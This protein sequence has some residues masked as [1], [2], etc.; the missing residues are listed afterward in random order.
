MPMNYPTVP[1]EI[2]STPTDIITILSS[3]AAAFLGAAAA[4]W[5]N[6]QERKK[7]E[8]RQRRELINNAIYTVSITVNTLINIKSQQL[9]LYKSEFQEILKC[10]SELNLHRPEVVEKTRRATAEILSKISQTD[11]NLNDVFKVWQ[12]TEFLTITAPE[13]LAFTVEETPDLV[14]LLM[15][16]RSEVKQVSKRTAYR[17]SVHTR[18][19][20]T[21]RGEMASGVPGPNTLIFWG[22]M[23]SLRLL[24][25]DHVD[26]ALGIVP[27]IIDQIGAYRT[28]AFKKT[29]LRKI[30]R[31]KEKWLVF[32]L[33]GKWKTFMPDRN[34]YQHIIRGV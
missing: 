29:L 30:L 19:E 8:R 10:L 28:R 6:S 26:T 15:I 13:D 21:L 27:E 5:F 11:S 32:S 33:Q 23:I 3:F 31:R 7:N 12:E 1:I 9:H 34:E 22:E 20:P 25:L 2:I 18:L 4:F 16:F 17:N 24:T 14:R